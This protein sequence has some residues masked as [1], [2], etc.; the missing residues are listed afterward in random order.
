[1]LQKIKKI[2]TI[3]SVV[4]GVVKG[5]VWAYEK[6]SVGTPLSDSDVSETVAAQIE[7]SVE[8]VND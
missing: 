6:L 7:K 1:M 8:D 4:N 3:L 5:A 2:A